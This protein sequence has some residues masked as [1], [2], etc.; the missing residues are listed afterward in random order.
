MVEVLEVIL[1]FLTSILV[2]TLDV[3]RC[4]YKYYCYRERKSYK[5]LVDEYPTLKRMDD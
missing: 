5:K 2:T 1:A 3:T 4:V